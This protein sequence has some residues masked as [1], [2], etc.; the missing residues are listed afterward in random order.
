MSPTASIIIPTRGRPGYLDVALASIAPQA[1]DAGAEVVVA[2]DGPDPLS[3]AVA[4]RHGA[5]VLELDPPRGANAARNAGVAASSAALVVLV[6]DDV[7]APPGWLDAY[8]EA[9]ISE[10]GHDVFG[11]PLYVR[12]EGVTLR[13]CGREGP[14]VSALD[15]G[16]ED[17]DTDVVWSA[18]MAARRAALDRIG[19]FNEELAGGGE[20]EEW[21]ER[22]RAAHGRVRYVAAAGVQHRRAPADSRRRALARAAW[23]RG[24]AVRRWDEYRGAAPSLAAELRVL[25][26]CVVHAARLRCETGALAGVHAAGRLREAL[27]RPTR[28]P[29]PPGAPRRHDGP[30]FASGDAGNVTGIRAT[31]R[32]VAADLAFDARRVLTG[33]QARLARAARR[34][35]APRRVLAVGIEREDVPNLMERTRRE[36]QQTRHDVQLRT[37]PAAGGGRFEN[38]NR[39]IDCSPLT[40]FDWLLVVD[41]DVLLPRGFLDRF[42]LIAERFDLR[43]AQPAHRRRSHAAWDMTRRRPASVAR[44]TAFVE[45]GPVTAFHSSTFEV[46]LPFPELRF[47]WGLD[48]HWAAVA[49]ERGW[50]VGVVDATPIRHGLRE[51]A[52]SYTHAE[53]FAEG[54]AFLATRPYLR[55]E[56]SRQTLAT[57][58]LGELLGSDGRR[59]R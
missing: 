11:G 56:E 38:L 30:D 40:G 42:L 27:R 57:H 25:G 1:A 3:A 21:E 31:T 36:L 53:A 34:D 17:R 52:T 19:P 5:T 12:L 33:E 41:D 2:L 20:E 29:S 55:A 15:L 4:R 46:L 47:G 9:A 18:N 35:P 16:G 8:L 45:I 48:A 50:R 43:L 28:T 24:R 39:L 49:R 59:P 14:P 10:Q 54:E 13:S 22:Y 44:E 26:G 23:R 7:V 37:C 32:A 51:I 58:S 6:D